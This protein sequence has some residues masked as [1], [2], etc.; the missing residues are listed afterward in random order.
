MFSWHLGGTPPNFPHDNIQQTPGTFRTPP[1][2]YMLGQ[3]AMQI[4]Q[5]WP[6]KWEEWTRGDHPRSCRP[7][8][9]DFVSNFQMNFEKPLVFF[10]HTK[11]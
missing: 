10:P 9:Q 7:T 6:L 8:P 11:F 5:A 4:D 1:V 2:T 3:D